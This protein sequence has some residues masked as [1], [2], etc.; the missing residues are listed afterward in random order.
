MRTHNDFRNWTTALAVGLLSTIAL[1]ATAPVWACPF[2]SAIA[3]TFAEQIASSDVV[4]IATLESEPSSPD[5]AQLPRANFKVVGVLTG[6]ELM[7]VG[8]KFEAVV[9]SRSNKLGE[10]FLIMGSGADTVNWTTPLKVSDRVVDYLNQL[11]LLPESGPER[12]AFFARH[13]E[14]EEDVLAYDAY[15][16]F[17]RASYDD[18][19]GLKDQLD[20]EKLI[21]WL[22]DPDVMK[23]RKRLYYTLLGVC[24]EE[25]EVD[26]LE[27]IL[28]SGDRDRQAGLDALIACYLTLTGDDGVS[29]IEE[30]FLAN[31]DAEYIDVFSAITALRFHGTE[32]D[33]VDLPRIVASLRLVLDRPKMAD[34]VIPDLARWED[35]SVMDRLV[36]MFKESDTDETRW[37]RTPIISY[38]QACPK[39][40]A[41]TYIVELR[42]ID[43]DAAKR[44]DMLADLDWGD[45]DD[46]WGD[47]EDDT[48]S[49]EKVSDKNDPGDNDQVTEQE[50]NAAG[51]EGESRAAEPSGKSGGGSDSSGPSDADQNPSANGQIPQIYDDGEPS[52][53]QANTAAATYVSTGSPEPPAPQLSPVTGTAEDQLAQ[54]TQ[55]TPPAAIISAGNPSRPV[56]I[57]VALGICIL[58]FVLL[59]SVL[60]GWFERLIF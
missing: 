36:V 24:G 19:K 45:E 44:A 50:T 9:V 31:P 15:D 4:V 16:E 30:L 56:M 57:L 17:A 47:E 7:P 32:A 35:W 40:E 42:E 18:V 39:P 14:D 34:M 13:F 43:P 59:W 1:V 21:G 33:K 12:L 49:E 25:S 20:R 54:R 60:N 48:S 10:K 11:K 2:C 37:V 51:G 52:S 27:D 23:S 46:D 26:F 41:K 28:K 5:E 29:L 55:S 22:E 6:A 3:Q 38:L 53:N 8:E 58:I